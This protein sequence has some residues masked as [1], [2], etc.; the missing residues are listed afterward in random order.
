[1]ENKFFVVRV[2]FDKDTGKQS[3]SVQSYD[4][5]T[6]ALKRYYTLL[7]ADID[8]DKYSYELVM[9]VS[10]DGVVIMSQVFDNRVQ[11]GS[12]MDDDKGTAAL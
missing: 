2:F 9:V 8:N 10:D 4:D 5:R 12:V 11:P 6:Q 1:M 3:N 7:G